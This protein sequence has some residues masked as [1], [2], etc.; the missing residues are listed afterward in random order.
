[1]ITNLRCHSPLPVLILLAFLCIALPSNGYSELIDKVVAVVNDEVITLSD[2]EKEGGAFFAKIRENATGISQQS[3]LTKARQEV[4]D[5][6]IDKRLIA[7]RAKQRN[8]AVSAQEVDSA[9][10]NAMR[11]NNLNRVQFDEQ[12]KKMG[13]PRQQYRANLKAQ[14]L[15]S[16][17]I[18]REVRSKIVV[19]EDAIQAYYNKEYTQQIEGDAYYLLQMGFSWDTDAKDLRAAKAEARDRAER[20]H[21]LA[22]QSED[23][24]EL[25]KTHS[26]LPSAADGGDLGYFAKDDMAPGMRE[27]VTSLKPGEVSD[28]L[29]TSSGF[30]FFKVLSSQDGQVI[31]QIPYEAAKEDIRN[32]LYET[33]LKNEFAIWIKQL[34]ERA[35]IK[36]L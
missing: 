16:K 21:A 4:L 25:A 23:F 34:K 30:Q 19:T 24:K 32:L 14:I 33:Q 28:I 31:Q 5:A 17:L 26:D 10:Q 9:V 1:M 36:R 12:L 35:Y 18:N 2:L 6:L 7:Q 13:I 3:A 11:R 22:T 29:E 15:Q 20:I 8:I 27:A